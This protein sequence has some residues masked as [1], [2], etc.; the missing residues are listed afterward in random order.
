VVGLLITF[1]V[2]SWAG[3]LL[4]SVLVDRHPLVF[5]AL[6]SRNRNLVLASP[7]LDAVSYYTVAF[8]RLV[9]SDPLFFLL[10]RWYGDSAVTWMERKAPSFGSLLRWVEQ[11]FSRAAYPLVALAP[12]N[13]ICLFAG[14]SGMGVAGFLVA[15][16]AGTMFRLYLLRTAG[17]VFS[18][19]LDSVTDW[20]ADHRLIVF[21]GS[22]IF[23]GLTIWS[24]RRAGGTEVTQ[25][26][27]LDDELTEAEADTDTD[28][29]TDADAEPTEGA[30]D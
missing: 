30:S 6:N 26:A 22:A 14:A 13:F 4:L 20:I 11:H 16:V 18:G 12:N 7:N 15:N 9:A 8:L 29:D 2:S 25:L 24:E 1:V 23:L 3:D 27:H 28:T 21:V 10:G 5:I 19:P 17:D